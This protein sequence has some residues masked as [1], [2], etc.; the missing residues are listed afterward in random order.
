MIEINEISLQD[1]DI[2]WDEHIKYLIEDGMT[3]D[4]DEI[5]YFSGR[6]YRGILEDHMIRNRDKQHMAYFCCNEKRIGA[7]SYCTYQ[8]ED[9]KC[10]ILDYWIFPEFRGN[11]LDSNVL[12]H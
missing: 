8:S 3:S 9:G 12:R 11:G 2:F 5:A 4:E 1:I 6:K 10:F 7:V